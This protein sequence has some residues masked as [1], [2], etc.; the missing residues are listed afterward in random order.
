[1]AKRLQVKNACVNCQRACKKC[2]DN[3][4]CSRCAKYGMEDS[5]ADS[6]RKE[7]IRGAKRGPYRKTLQGQTAPDYF[8]DTQEAPVEN[9]DVLA[10]VCSDFLLEESRNEFVLRHLRK[11]KIELLKQ[12]YNQ[13]TPIATPQPLRTCMDQTFSPIKRI[14]PTPPTTP[15]IVLKTSEE[16]KSYVMLK[17]SEPGCQP[18][19]AVVR[20]RAASS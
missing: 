6:S 8:S 20:P 12:T 9:I 19:A 13:V 10:A 7:R 15:S 3:R 14:I 5:C 11:R 16:A 18:I 1:M 4:P 2:D 17:L